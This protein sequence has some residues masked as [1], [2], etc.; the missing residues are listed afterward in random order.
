LEFGELGPCGE[1]QLV[2]G[3]GAAAEAPAALDGLGEQ[4]PGAVDQ[5]RVAGRGGDDPGQL[6]DDGELFVA[7]E[8]ASVGEDLD[9]DVSVVSIHIGE[10]VGREVVDE[11][12]GVGS[13]H[14]D[15]RHLLDGHDGGGQVDRELVV[16]GECPGRRVD[17]DHGHGGPPYAC[18]ACWTSSA[19]SPGCETI[20]T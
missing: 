3:I 15:V 9:P 2:V 11:R 18:V 12:G 19:T 17:V 1:D 20:A 13:E 14:W 8:G 10:T 16:V 4:D 6:L 7:V 5:F